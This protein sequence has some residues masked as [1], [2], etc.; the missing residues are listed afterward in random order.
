MIPWVGPKL[1]AMVATLQG[2]IKLK[3][4]FKSSDECLYTLPRT[5]FISCIR[6]TASLI[7]FFSFATECNLLFTGQTPDSTLTFIPPTGVSQKTINV[8]VNNSCSFYF[9]EK[10]HSHYIGCDG[11]WR[12]IPA[13]S[14]NESLEVTPGWNKNQ[15]EIKV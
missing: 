11:A 9:G 12:E 15:L 10:L 1:R 7:P 5:N 2:A 6:W 3:G 14:V 13:N 4:F 8:P